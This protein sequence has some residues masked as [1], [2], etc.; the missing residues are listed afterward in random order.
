M[1]TT[2]KIINQFQ[3]LNSWCCCN[4][5][6]GAPRRS[7]WGF[8]FHFLWHINTISSSKVLYSDDAHGCSGETFQKMF[9][10][11]TIIFKKFMITYINVWS[12]YNYFLWGLG[13]GYRGFQSF[14]LSLTVLCQTE[15]RHLGGGVYFGGFRTPNFFGLWL[16]QLICKYKKCKITI[17]VRHFETTQTVVMLWY[18][19]IYLFILCLQLPA[20]FLFFF[21]G[22]NLL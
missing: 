11:N 12:Q 16:R 20:H 15:H 13:W 9:D 10:P 5:S 4:S 18:L 14:C 2:N 1:N 21:Q 3:Y 6:H 22:C 19:N 17:F 7:F 8:V